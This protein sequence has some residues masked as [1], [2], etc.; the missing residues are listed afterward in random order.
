MSL[1]LPGWVEDAFFLVGLPW[2]AVDEDELKGWAQDLRG[3]ADDIT[4]LSK[5]SHDVI[6]ELA[7]SSQSAFLTT[8]AQHWQHHHQQIMAMRGPMDAFAEALD[9]AAEA[10]MIQKRLVIAAAIT[11]AGEVIATQGEA[12]VTFGLAE[13]ELPLEVEATKTAV[14]LVLQELEMKLIG[15]LVNHAAKD[16]GEHLSN[17]IRQLLMGGAQVGLESWTLKADT[18]AMR[19]VAGTVRTHAHRTERVSDETH[20]RATNRR[21]ET[22]SRGGK[23]PVIAIVEA[24]LLSLAKDIFQALPRTVH[25]LMAEA[26]EGLDNGAHTIEEADA[27]AADNVPHEDAAP[28]G[29]APG[30]GGEPP[31]PP[32]I[33]NGGAAGDEGGEEGDGG[34]EGTNDDRE[35]PEDGEG[36]GSDG[37]SGMP[38]WLK[39]VRSG[40]KFNKD[41]HHR[42][43]YNEVAVDG[44]KDGAPRYLDSYESGKEIV[45]RKE[46]QLAEVKPET[47]NGYLDEL[48]KKYSPGT[49]IRSRK[50]PELNGKRLK[51]QMILEV[52]VQTGTVPAEVLAH[53]RELKIIIRDITGH[54][55]T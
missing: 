38:D 21:L 17:T 51:G 27:R 36:A 35:G 48:A 41:N 18:K 28:A 53:A 37:G 19:R 32:G 43:K 55:Y 16:I 12:L 1:E 25:Q 8:M 7:H 29:S 4:A 42:F 31:V 49:L 9:V 20:R 54:V 24:A 5:A 34:G 2:P 23:W 50:Y 11:L 10:V 14:K 30:G 46:S 40:D 33:G 3:F 47:A 45:S 13:G 22:R 6:G 44:G 15:A 39:K 26:E 52:P